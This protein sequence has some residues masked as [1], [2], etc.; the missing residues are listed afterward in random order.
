[1][2]DKM[3]KIF[4][5]TKME[6]DELF[7]GNPHT[8]A[9]DIKDKFETKWVETHAGCF[10]AECRSDAEYY[11]DT[12]EF[13]MANDGEYPEQHYDNVIV[14]DRTAKTICKYYT[15]QDGISKSYESLIRFLYREGGLEIGN[16]QRIELKE[17]SDRKV[18]R[19]TAR[20]TGAYLF[21]PRFFMVY[22]VHRETRWDY[23][24]DGKELRTETRKL[25]W[26]KK[27]VVCQPDRRRNEYFVVDAA[28]QHV[29]VSP[30]H[31]VWYR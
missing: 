31:M 21:K 24:D 9:K 15:G 30:H 23:T 5:G 4:P 6:L 17:I 12:V 19:G 29:V 13:A 27:T 11:T 26:D 20:K 16:K 14:P 10:P 2:K 8:T 7:K 18:P 28:S 22:E 25:T 3:F 1:M